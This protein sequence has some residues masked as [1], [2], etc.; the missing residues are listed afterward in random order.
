M[1]NIEV[2][3]RCGDL[4]RARI[5]AREIGAVPH[6][7]LHQVDT[8]FR[9]PAGR[10]KLRE[11][12][13]AELVFYKRSNDPVAR[14]SDYE[15]VPVEAPAEL[16]RTLDRALGTWRIVTKRR[17]LWKLDNIRIHLDR[18][19][20]LGSFI[21]FEAVVDERHPDDDC[22][23]ALARLTA[24]FGIGDGDRIGGSYSDL[25]V[26]GGCADRSDSLDGR[27]ESF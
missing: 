2:K 20:G 9:V 8:Y 22:R 16:K 15:L 27:Q 23:A 14:E 1:K 17:E 4:D 19:E 10:L 24:A 21:E 26:I 5:V 12:A 7:I 18:V 11:S 3:A 25:P 6:G 13:E